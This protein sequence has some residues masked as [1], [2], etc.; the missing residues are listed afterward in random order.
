MRVIIAGGH[1]KIAL[2]LERMLA[3]DGHQPVAIIRNPAHAGDVEAAGAEAL[4]LDFES[5]NAET[6]AR[7]LA[8]A[9]AVVFA[10]GAGPDSGAARKLTVDRDG[11]ILLA[12]AA[13]R[14]GIR[15]YV[16]VS[17]IGADGYDPD[18]AGEDGDVFQV[19][20][21]A[22]ADADADLR[23]RDLDW[24]IV[25][26][27]GLTDEAGSGL[28]AVGERLER[29]SV[30]RADVAAVLLVLLETGSAVR[31]QFELTRGTIPIAQAL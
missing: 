15:R 25:R 26:P 7:H 9:D 30:P 20:L 27:G 2:L 8:N 5:T 12:D 19:Y 23:A 18:Q 13:E 28:V 22:K 6:L 17:A 21:K 16:L 29:D 14:A 31:E 3:D 24:T 10:A 4:V 11:A 1:G